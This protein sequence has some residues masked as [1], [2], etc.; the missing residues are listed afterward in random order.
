MNSYIH[1]EAQHLLTASLTS[2]CTP[3]TH[4][5]SLLWYYIYSVPILVDDKGLREIG[6][7][8]HDALNTKN[9]ILE[10]FV[11]YASIVEKS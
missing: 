3:A 4:K 10:T 6:T 5:K 11:H 2:N 8:L 7:S 9:V 1:R